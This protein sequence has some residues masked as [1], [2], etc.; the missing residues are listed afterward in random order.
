M[1]LAEGGLT[2]VEVT[3]STPG[4]FSAVERLSREGLHVGVGTITDAVAV[5]AAADAGAGFVVSFTSPR[6]FV[7]A[8]VARHVLAIPGAMTPSEAHSAAAAGASLVKLFPARVLGPEI[9]SDLRPLVEGV[10]FV[11]TGGIPLTGEGVGSWMRAGAAAIG[12]GRALGEVGDVGARE[13]TRRARHARDL[14]AE[15]RADYAAPR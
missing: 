11:A 7:A 10:R 14:V 13:V 9:V 15:A 6:G 12:I 3:L 2:T 5:D 8:A 1:A 4:V